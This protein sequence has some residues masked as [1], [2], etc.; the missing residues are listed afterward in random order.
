VQKAEQDKATKDHQIRNLND[1]IAHQDELINKLNK[2]KKMQ[3]ESNQKTGEELQAAEVALKKGSS[4][5]ICTHSTGNSSGSANA[6][7]A[8]SASK[9]VYCYM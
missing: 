6:Q 7:F 8:K 9:Y 1:E 2:E 5:Q 4:C 3:G